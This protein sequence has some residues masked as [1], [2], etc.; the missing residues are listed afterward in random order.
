MDFWTPNF[1]ALY[2]HSKGEVVKLKD[3][4]FEMENSSKIFILL[5][6]IM[7]L[8]PGNKPGT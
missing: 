8:L 2:Y 3:L 7:I 4:I 5:N 6:S 1:L